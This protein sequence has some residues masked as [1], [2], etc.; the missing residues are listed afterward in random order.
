M[1][2][3]THQEIVKRQEHKSQ[4]L[5]PPLTVVLNNIRSLFNVGS[6]FRTADGAGVEKIW[7]CGYTGFPP[8]S[9][10]T[11]TALGAEDRVPWEHEKDV[12]KV[13]KDLKEKGYQIVLLEQ[14]KQ[15]IDYHE[16]EP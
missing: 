16:F 8:Q 5:R 2:K 3:L 14:L 10:I 11:K 4:E 13:I 7:L 12:V 9:Q 1:R 15:S 6:I